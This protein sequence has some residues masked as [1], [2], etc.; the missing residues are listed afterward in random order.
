MCSSTLAHLNAGGVG[1]DPRQRAMLSKI[2][3]GITAGVCTRSGVLK[4]LVGGD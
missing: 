2:A 1:L 4:S 3:Q